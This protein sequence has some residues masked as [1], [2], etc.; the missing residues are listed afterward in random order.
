MTEQERLQAEK[1]ERKAE[2]ERRKT[3]KERAER[4]K[5]EREHDRAERERL[6][7]EREKNRLIEPPADL[8]EE[9]KQ[10]WNHIYQILLSGTNYRKTMADAELIRHYVQ[11]KLMRDRAWAE[12][13]KKPE[14]YIRIVTGLCAD[15]TTPKVMVKEN[16]HY[17]ILNNSNRQLQK[18]LDDFKLTPKARSSY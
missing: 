11:V 18:L 15:G 3:E 13:N 9:E 17:V 12:W 7:R 1:E 14:R 5:R 10:A 4:E 6:E 8:T 2:R 16:E